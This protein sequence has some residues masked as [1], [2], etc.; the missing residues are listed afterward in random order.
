MT[1]VAYR[2]QAFA[3]SVSSD[4]A[5]STLGGVALQQWSITARAFSFLV[6]KP[7]ANA[8]LPDELPT[9][10]L[11][12]HVKARQIASRNMLDPVDGDSPTC[13][14]LGFSGPADLSSLDVLL[15]ITLWS[16]KQV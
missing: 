2:L 14:L 10:A 12:H 15:S 7:A 16:N 4:I 11:M 5:K 13:T 3:L 6:N 9:L 8:P 1:Q